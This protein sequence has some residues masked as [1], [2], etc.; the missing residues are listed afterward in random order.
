MILALDVGNTQIFGGLVDAGEVV[1][2][3]RRAS[4]TGASSDEIGIFLRMV[5][6]EN[7]FDAAKVQK[8]AVCSVVPSDN[9]SL[10]SACLKYFEIAPFFVDASIHTGLA[11]MC[12][13][14][15]EV[16]ADRIANAIAAVHF[17]PGKNLIVI[18]SGT[19]TTFC[20]IS[21]E[22][23][24]L[25]GVILAGLRLQNEALGAKAAKLSNVEIRKAETALGVNTISSM[26]SGLYFGHLGAMRE[27]IGQLNNECFGGKPAYVIGTGGFASLFETAQ[28]FDEIMP[29]LIIHGLL[30]AIDLNQI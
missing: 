14:P 16:G 8:I 17:H 26:Q 22:S 23:E 15:L 28:I 13:N 24:Y 9:H 27:I 30:K 20:A 5:L 21:E 4:K 25:G 2:C 10:A 11:N 7:G 19:A 12:E 29:D 18:D 3:F 1:F 6:R